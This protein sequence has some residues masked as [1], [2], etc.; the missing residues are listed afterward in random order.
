MGG[1]LFVVH[2]DDLDAFIQA[3][4]VDVDDVAAAQGEYDVHA[5]VLE[6]LGDQVAARNFLLGY[7]QFGNLT[8]RVR[9]GESP[10]SRLLRVRVETREP[11]LVSCLRDGT[12]H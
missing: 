10:V 5:L 12:G 2:V 6:G 11:A 4:V 3:A 1:H 9:H 7:L 8:R